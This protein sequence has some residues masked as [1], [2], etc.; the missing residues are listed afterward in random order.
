MDF[1]ITSAEQLKSLILVAVGDPNISS[2]EF[3]MFWDWAVDESEKWLSFNEW[4]KFCM[5]NGLA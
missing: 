3:G 2:E 1:Q 5:D 4:E